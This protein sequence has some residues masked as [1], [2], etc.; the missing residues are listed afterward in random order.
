M[1]ITSAMALGNTLRTH[2]FRA[3]NS[4]RVTIFPIR[5]VPMRANLA[6]AHIARKPSHRGP[7]SSVLGFYGE[8]P[9]GASAFPSST[10]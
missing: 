5:R 10:E 4:R 2:L 6:L 7:R 8:Q 3:R 9:A 1:I